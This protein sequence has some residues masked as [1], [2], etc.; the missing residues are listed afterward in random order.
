MSRL[1]DGYQTL[2]SFANAPG[3]GGLVIWEKEVTPPGYEGGGPNDTTTMRNLFF[4]TRQPKYLVT[5]SPMNC[6]V[7]YDPAAYDD[8]FNL[9]LN[10]NQLIS[11]TFP[12]TQVLSFWGWM[13]EFKPNSHKEGEQPTAGIVLI[14]SNENNL[15]VEVS[16]ILT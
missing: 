10:T 16:P 13:D 5:L 7:A 1:N 12:D 9:V 15:G 3:I 2:I 6:T 8:L 11:V 4:R 14:P